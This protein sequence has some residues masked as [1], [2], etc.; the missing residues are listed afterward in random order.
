[1]YIY[2][3]I[4]IHIYIYIHILMYKYICIYIHIYIY[5]Y[6]YMYIVSRGVD[7][8]RTHESSRHAETRRTLYVFAFGMMNTYEWVSVTRT[9]QCH[10]YKWVMS[11]VRMSHV[12]RMEWVVAHT[13]I[14]GYTKIRWRIYVLSIGMMLP[15]KCVMSHVSES[16]CTHKESWHCQFFMYTHAANHGT[17]G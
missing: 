5:I 3:H 16:C 12:R 2:I 13:R 11:H 1:M 4:Y 7:G 10:M 8:S 14:L 6:I 9:N 15:K 17:K